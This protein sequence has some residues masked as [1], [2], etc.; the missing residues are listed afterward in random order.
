LELQSITLSGFRRFAQETEL[1]TN[2][3][4]VA[5]LGPNEAGKTSLL[6]AMTHIGNNK[7]FARSDLTRGRAIGDDD[8]II[9]SR[10]RLDDDDL[11]A[12]KL[13][14]PTCYVLSKEVSGQQTYSFEPGVPRRD[15]SNRAKIFT[16]IDRVR[17][18]NKLWGRLVQ[19]HDDAIQ[20]F[21]EAVAS[22]ALAEE[23][24]DEDSLDALRALGAFSKANHLAN[25]PMYFRDLST[26]I[27]NQIA[28]ENEKT[29]EQFAKEVI[30][31]RL[32]KVLFF[33]NEDRLLKGSYSMEELAE[34]VPPALENLC[35][36]AK[37]DVNDL[38]TAIQ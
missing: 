19:Q 3:K 9:R 11:A 14:Q 7:S 29:P 5:I 12:A 8:V 21:D 13:D 10:F 34:G 35:K 27:T 2:G 1:R 38:I 28:Q 6:R 16:S 26:H 24:L 32:P 17:T 22:L 4:L 33:S 18:N 30:Y 25:D 20:I 15:I 37:I 31:S 23:T 36:V